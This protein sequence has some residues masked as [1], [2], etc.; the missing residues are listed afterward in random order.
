MTKDEERKQ[1]AK[2]AKLINDCGP[3]SYIATAFKGCV[4][5]AQRNIDEDAAY[6]SEEYAEALKAK[7]E[8]L[9]AELAQAQGVA[10][11]AT[12]YADHLKEMRLPDDECIRIHSILSRYATI[13]YQKAEKL[14][15][16]ALEL[17][18]DENGDKVLDLLSQRAN[19]RAE[20]KDVIKSQEAIATYRAKM[21]GL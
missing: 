14:E 8:K 6:S 5:N 9:E 10:K 21:R 13:V 4:E 11:V 18:P 1:L 16:E 17:D 3:D 2:I 7:G 15:A 12:E 19:R 20:Y